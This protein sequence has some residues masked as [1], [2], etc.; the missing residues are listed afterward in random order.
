M[1]KL[2]KKITRSIILLISSILLF[3]SNSL[4]QGVWT[5]KADCPI[6]ISNRCVGFSI[7]TNGYIGTGQDSTYASSKSFWEY[8][9]A[10]DSWTQ[11]ADFDGSARHGAVGF[12]IGSKGYI[13]T[14]LSGSTFLNDF[15]EYDPS[16]NSWT[17]KA[18]LPGPPRIYGTGFSIL[19]KGYI[20]NG[21]TTASGDFTND[22]WEYDPIVDTWTALSFPGIGRGPGVGFSIGS[23]GYFG[24]GNGGAIDFPQSDFWKF[25]PS[26]NSWSQL[27]NIPIPKCGAAGFSLFGKGYIG[28][29]ADSLSLAFP[30]SSRD[31]WE[32]DPSLNTWTQ[33]ADFG[34]TARSH[35]VAFSIG[36]IGYMGSGDNTKDFWAYDPNALGL[37]ELQNT[38]QISV[39]PN[40]S[41]GQFNFNG[42]EK[43]NKI[44]VFDMTGKLIFEGRATSDFETI[45]ISEN[46]KG[47]YFYRITDESKLVQSGKIALQ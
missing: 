2:T 15:W 38:P 18:N 31:F 9:P 7:G 20:G 25:D 21:D 16:L 3:T 22:F 32:Y 27:A 47:I 41:S 1:I 34:G 12:S 36:S 35:A 26:T 43:G 10:T 33:K 29:G 45:N 8:E 23:M 14:G 6:G 19:N 4:S 40:P 44:E 37:N 28:T 5:K 39:Y 30:L 11:K 24:T 17:T 46:A 13:G 42:L